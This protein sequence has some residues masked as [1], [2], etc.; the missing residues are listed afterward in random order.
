MIISAILYIVGAFVTL[1]SSA[2][3]A[4]SYAIPGNFQTAIHYFFGYLG[5]LRGVLPIDNILTA[6]GSFITFLTYWYAIKLIL[7]IYSLVPWI[8]KTTTLPNI[9]ESNIVDLRPQSSGR[10]T[11]DL[12][13]KR[14]KNIMRNTR[15]IR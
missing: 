5:Y 4:I 12:R 3:S 10:N 8:G 9:P 7:W 11:L 1:V 2:F 15:D 14:G 13:K 6:M